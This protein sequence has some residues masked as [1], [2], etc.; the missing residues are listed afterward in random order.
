[1][2]AHSVHTTENATAEEIAQVL[3][4]DVTRLHGVPHAILSDKDF[5]LTSKVWRCLCRVPGIRA[6][7]GLPPSDGLPGGKDQPHHRADAA[8]CIARRRDRMEI[9]PPAA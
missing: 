9:A 2:M 4:R 5:W 7:H 8:L 3:V 1:M 6:V